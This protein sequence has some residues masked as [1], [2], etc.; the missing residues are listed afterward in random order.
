LPAAQKGK[1]ISLFL[2][3]FEDEAR[4][5]INGKVV[6]TSGQRFSQPVAF[7]LT[8]G[9]NYDGENVVAIQFIRNSA[10]NEIGLGGLMRPCFFFTGP[11]LETRAPAPMELR[12]ILPGG[13]RGEV[14]K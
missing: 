1:P 8:D 9:I 12:R 14:E 4:V 10:A 7:D 6:G 2:G 3:G 5:W 11:R 13:E